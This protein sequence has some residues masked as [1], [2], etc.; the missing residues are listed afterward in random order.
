MGEGC[1]IHIL[2]KLLVEVGPSFGE[3]RFRGENPP[4]VRVWH[5]RFFNT[6]DIVVRQE[7]LFDRWS[8]LRIVF[9]GFRRDALNG[10]G[11]HVLDKFVLIAVCI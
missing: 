1:L 9:H 4:L 2:V 8:H 5:I 10:D 3:F 11:S 7:I 6:Y